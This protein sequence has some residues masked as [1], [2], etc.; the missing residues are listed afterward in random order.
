MSIVAEGGTAIEIEKIPLSSSKTSLL[1]TLPG[2]VFLS[3]IIRLN[4]HS[5]LIYISTKRCIS[6]IFT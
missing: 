2:A 6:C 3:M 4:C 5:E 1:F